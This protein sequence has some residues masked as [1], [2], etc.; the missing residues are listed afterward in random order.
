MTDLRELL[1]TPA[2]DTDPSQQLARVRAML[3]AA[4]HLKQFDPKAVMVLPRTLHDA[5]AD[6]MRQD[7]GAGSQVL[8]ARGQSFTFAE[9]PLVPQDEDHYITVIAPAHEVAPRHFEFTDPPTAPPRG[10][11]QPP[12]RR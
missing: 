2:D 12:G 1:K 6:K 11:S 5:Y 9:M 3:Q 4:F 8:F 7:H 10:G